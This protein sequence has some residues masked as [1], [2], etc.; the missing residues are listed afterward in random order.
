MSVADRLALL[1]Q[2]GLFIFAFY[3]TYRAFA[4]AKRRLL[5]WYL[6]RHGLKVLPT[7]NVEFLIKSQQAMTAKQFH[8]LTNK[9]PQCFEQGT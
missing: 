7:D 1:F 6:E 3:L 2:L 8:A 9:F 4:P 5:T